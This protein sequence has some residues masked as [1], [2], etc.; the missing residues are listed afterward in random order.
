MRM[1]LWFRSIHWQIYVVLSE[2]IPQQQSILSLWNEAAGSHC[3]IFIYR[4]STNMQKHL[5]H[6]TTGAYYNRATPLKR[7]VSLLKHAIDFRTPF[8]ASLLQ[9]RPGWSQLSSFVAK[10]LA[11]VWSTREEYIICASRG[12]KIYYSLLICGGCD[13]VLLQS[14]Y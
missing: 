12:E 10:H 2:G 9:H 3:S 1:E 7:S 14:L 5:N 4:T 6:F 8:H 11:S 13:H